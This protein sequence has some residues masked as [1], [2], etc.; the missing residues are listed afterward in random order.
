MKRAVVL[1]SGGLDSATATAWARGR[2]F[3]VIA[4]TVDYGQRH[5]A[6]LDAARAVAT[7][8]G[9]RDHRFIGVDLRAIGGSALTAEID[10]PLDRAQIGSGV[11]VTY[12][13]ARNLVFLG[14]LAGL[15][16]V[17][18]A[19][20]LVIGVNALDYSGYPDC[21]PEFLHAFAEAVRLGTK[22]GVEQ[23]GFE[24]HAPLLH[25]SKAGIIRL[26][27]ALGVDYS[28]TLSC[29][30]PPRAFVHCGRCDAC[31]LRRAGFVEAHLP[32]PTVYAA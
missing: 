30:D 10:V 29:Y 16:E 9:V 3:E 24:V 22:V 32:D 7:S 23:G 21:R 15:G 26:G 13:P 25:L 2:G 18:G 4:L 17:V 8:L 12:V 27:A 5:R 20:D 28:R 6:E 14:L 31:Q 1:L 11:P 19:R